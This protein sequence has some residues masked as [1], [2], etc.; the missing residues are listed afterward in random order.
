MTLD[1]LVT[2]I[3]SRNVA[4]TQRLINRLLDIRIKVMYLEFSMH[5]GGSVHIT[6]HNASV[7]LLVTNHNVSISFAV[8]YMVQ[9]TFPSLLFNSHANPVLTHTHTHTN[10]RTHTHTKDPMAITFCC[11]IFSTCNLTTPTILCSPLC[12]INKGPGHWRAECWSHKKRRLKPIY[13]YTRN[14][15]TSPFICN[16]LL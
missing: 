10:T 5:I 4:T 16:R 12:S 13:V 7:A 6:L 1:S 2:M 9:Y 15:F 11:S 8:L 3:P 14:Y